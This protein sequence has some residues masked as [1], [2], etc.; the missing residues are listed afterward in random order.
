MVHAFNG[1]GTGVALV[2]PFTK[3]NTVDF[4]ALEALTRF[5]IAGGVD[6]VVALGTTGES[7]T[8]T[9]EEKKSVVACIAQ[10]TEGKAAVVLGLGGN[11]T[12]ELLA[13]LDYF[14]FSNVSG[15]LSVT[16]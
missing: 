1:K 7:T 14:D 2:T 6:Y 9:K 10:A 3:K 11:N 12:A 5:V 8:L 4:K 15:I 16:H 13:Y